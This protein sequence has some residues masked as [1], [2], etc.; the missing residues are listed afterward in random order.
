MDVGT[1]LMTIGTLLTA[2]FTGGTMWLKIQESKVT[3]IPVADGDFLLS[4]NSPRTVVVRK[5]VA[6]RGTV[7]AHIASD[8]GRSV[9]GDSESK[10]KNVELY[11]PPYS[12]KRLNYGVC[13]QGQR[14]VVKG[15]VRRVHWHQP[16]FVD[17]VLYPDSPLTKDE[18][19]SEP[20]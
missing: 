11:L 2:V 4:N 10:M 9:W 20:T 7:W 5:I 3:V 15:K 19:S 16:S 17:I 14:Y 13:S 8:H 6:G 12:E 18:T 1:F